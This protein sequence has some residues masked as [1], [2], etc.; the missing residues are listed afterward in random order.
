M[1][2]GD[3][4]IHLDA[5]K[6]RLNP[7]ESLAA[8]VMAEKSTVQMVFLR[9][10]TLTLDDHSTVKFGEG[11]P[12]QHFPLTLAVPTSLADHYYLARCGVKRKGK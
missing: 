11:V 7:G 1:M 2:D 8:K 3:E 9:P 12:W 5:Y 6:A 4:R 10:V